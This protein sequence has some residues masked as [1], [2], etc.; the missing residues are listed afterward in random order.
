MHNPDRRYDID[1]LRVIAIGLLLVYHSSICF[2]PWGFMLGFITND[3]SFESLWIPMTML[4]VWRIPLLFYISGMGTYFACQHKTWK[5]LLQERTQ[6]ILIPFIAGIFVIVP[7][8]IGISQHYYHISINYNFHAAHLWFLGNVFIYILLL[9]PCFYYLRNN[10][11]SR[12]FIWIRRLCG[13]PIILL[14]VIIST[15]SETLLISPS[16]YELYAMTWHG[17]F[18]GM[19]AYF[20]GFCFMLGGAPFCDTLLKWKWSFLVLAISLYIYRLMQV[21]MKVSHLLLAIE[22]SS[23]TFAVLAFGHKYLNHA[24]KTLRY[25]SQA[26]YP[27]YII[28]MISLNLSLLLILPLQLDAHWKFVLVLSFTVSGNLI[29]YEFLIRRF[30]FTRILFGL[31]P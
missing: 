2:Q 15:I 12:F 19:L 28:H 25:L 17:F 16:L 21:Q 22:S 1:W 26:A 20:F 13:H 8:Q 9:S 29:L 7:I 31:K 24:G 10:K 18:L 3:K 4:N 6:R 14:L 23:W 30:R 11:D 27:I 5:Q